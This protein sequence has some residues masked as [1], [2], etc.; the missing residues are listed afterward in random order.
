MNQKE[1]FASLELLDKKIRFVLGEF[2]NNQLNVLN[3][4]FQDTDAIDNYN[5]IDVNQLSHD[6]K[7]LIKQVSSKMENNL[8]NVILLIPSF[9]MKRY[10]KRIKMALD[11]N[12]INKELFVDTINEIINDEMLDSEIL[13]NTNINRYLIDGVNTNK[14]DFEKAMN[15]LYVDVDFYV[16]NKD[17]IFDYLNAVEKSGLTILDIC[18][19][20]IAMASEMALLEASHL[21]NILI[22]KY[23]LNDLVISFLSEG[24]IVST[25]QINNGYN[26]L[27]NKVFND[28]DLSFDRAKQLILTNDYLNINE[29]V[30]MPVYLYYNGN[31][32]VAI[33]DHY[34]NA[35][36]IEIFKQQFSEIAMMIDPILMAKDTDIY[37]SGSGA[38][39]SGLDEFISNILR[40][41]VKKYV[42]ATLGARNSS[43]IANL[44]AM[45][46]YRDE[47]IFRILPEVENTIE[48]N[49]KEEKIMTRDESQDSMTNRFKELF[50]INKQ[51]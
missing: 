4:S 15:S 3:V 31:E 48:F 43:L 49:I 33:D 29:L 18:F 50:K 19:E 13:V 46:A 17:L 16:G 36:A 45:Y 25:T 2:H 41:K 39:I 28:H 7:T 35:L 51:N 27:I 6:I 8:N 11:N 1:I 22:I 5:I 12:H 9:I 40:N 37:L 26:D 34:L 10:S 47:N 23:E 42:P 32:T 38:M 14:I 24:R 21:K 20:N 30:S 44:G